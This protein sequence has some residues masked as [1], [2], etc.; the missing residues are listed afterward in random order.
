MVSTKKK[1]VKG[2]N[3][4]PKKKVV[5]KKNTSRKTSVKKNAHPDKLFILVDGKKVKNIKEL[6]DVMGDLEDY[7]FNHHVREDSNDFENWLTHVIEDIE[8]AK[9]IAGCKDKKH[10]QFVLYRHIAHKL[11]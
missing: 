11:W 9:N 8:L 1:S 7:V 10:V 5:F 3:S 6:A 4:T 2:V